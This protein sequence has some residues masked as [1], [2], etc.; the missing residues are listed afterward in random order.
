MGDI[1]NF[2]ATTQIKYKVV[3]F[4]EFRLANSAV[5]HEETHVR[6]VYLFFKNTMH[7]YFLQLLVQNLTAK[8]ARFK[9]KNYKISYHFMYAFLSTII[10]LSLTS[11]FLRQKL[12]TQK[13]W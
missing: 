1:V 13:N 7:K 6:L 5:Q 2:L 9:Q 10:Y 12:Q 8:H 3:E 11:I 4:V